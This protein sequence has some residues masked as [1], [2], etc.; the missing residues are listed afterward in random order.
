MK[1][2]TIEIDIYMFY[3]IFNIV[4]VYFCY[5]LYFANYIVFYSSSN[6]GNVHLIIKNI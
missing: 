2:M 4:I 3:F 1:V 5:I 6:R